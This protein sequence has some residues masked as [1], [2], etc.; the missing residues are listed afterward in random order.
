MK[1]TVENLKEETYMVI[2]ISREYGAYGRSVAKALSKR[3]GIEYYDVD[4]VRMTAK[5]SGY[6]EEDVSRE[7]ETLSAGS[8]FINSFLSTSAYNSSYDEIF[9]AQKE[10]VLELAKKTCI[11]VGRCSN[12]ILREAGVRTFDVFLH[13]DHDF[14][15]AHA[16]ELNEY[17]KVDVDRYMD[18]CDHW[19]KTYYRA[20]TG[21]EMGN[22]HDHDLSIDV[23]KIGFDRTVELLVS[24]LKDMLAD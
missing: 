11:M 3:L 15:K 12:I 10:V 9:L 4:F 23:G 24:L 2:T 14:R 13:A 6:S 1:G 17:G 5:K 16:M 20:Y 19:R 8:R 22:Y 7:G 21:H 18:R